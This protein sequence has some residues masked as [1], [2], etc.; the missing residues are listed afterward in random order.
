MGVFYHFYKEVCRFFGSHAIG[1]PIR[2]FFYKLSGVKVGRN[3][4]LN[5]G[6]TIIDN[7]HKNMI[8]IEDGVS[9]AP[10]VTLVAKSSPMYIHPAVK[11]ESL[12]IKEGRILIKEGCWIGTGAVILPGVTLGKCS[13]VGANAVVNKDVPDFTIVAGIPAQPIRQIERR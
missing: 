11:R 9:F 3:V 6:L 13:M 4:L 5:Q 12:P 10:N 1:N 7:G 8:V 2:I